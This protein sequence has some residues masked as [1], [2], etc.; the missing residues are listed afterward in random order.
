MVRTYQTCS[1]TLSLGIKPLGLKLAQHDV[2]MHLLLGQALTQQQL[3]ERSYVTKSHMSALLIEMQALGWIDRIGS[4]TDK[5]S[6][7]IAL[8]EQGMA[9]AQQAWQL[10]ERVIQTMMAPLS[11]AQMEDLQRF[12]VR[13][14]QDL[15]AFQQVL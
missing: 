10:Q 13:A 2:L 9:L 6:K 11:D 1:E 7:V 5:R 15:L 8:T 14:H 4:E 3:A 12:S